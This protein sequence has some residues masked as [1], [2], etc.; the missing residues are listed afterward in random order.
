LKFGSEYA[1][2]RDE[3]ARTAK[4]ESKKRKPKRARR[5]T[6]PAEEAAAAPAPVE[7]KE[8]EDERS[9]FSMPAAA[10]V[11]VPVV[12]EDASESDSDSD[13]SVDEEVLD[14]RL[15]D[16]AAAAPLAPASSATVSSRSSLFGARRAAAPAPASGRRGGRGG[17]RGG[18]RGDRRD[19]RRERRAPTGPRAP[20]RRHK[21]AVDTNIISLSLGHLAEAAAPATGDPVFCEGCGAALNALSNVKDAAGKPVFGPLA[22]AAE[23]EDKKEEDDAAVIGDG[24]QHWECEF[25]GFD[26]EVDVDE[27]E[28]PSEASLEYLL[29][30]GPAAV[31]HGAAGGEEGARAADDAMVVYVLD[32]SGS[33]CVSHEVQGKVAFRGDRSGSMRGLLGRGDDTA[34]RLP[35]QRKD[36]T[37]V[38]RLQAVQAA[39]TSQIAA[40][41]REHPNQRAA[42]I[43]FNNEVCILGDGTADPKTLAGDRLNSQAQML[44]AG[45]EVAMPGAVESTA[46]DLTSK[47][48]ALEEG[49]ATALGP[50][51]AAAVGL[52]SRKAGSRI[53]LA[54]D[55]L[56]NVGLGSLEVTDADRVAASAGAV[57]ED[58]DEMSEEDVARA[59]ATDFYTELGRAAADAGVVVDVVGLAACDLEMLGTT[60]CETTGGEV[61]KVDPA[62]LR[63]EFATSLANPVLAM[64]VTATLLLH[65]GLAFRGDDEDG[66]AEGSAPRALPRVSVAGG[67]AGGD[68]ARAPMNASKKERDIGNVTSDTV[69]TFEYGQKAVGELGERVSEMRAL[70]SL[71]FQLQVRYT[72]PDGA[73]YVRVLSQAKPVTHERAAAEAGM[74][75]RVCGTHVAQ[76]SAGLARAGHYKAARVRNFAFEKMMRRNVRDEKQAAGYGAWAAAGAAMDEVVATELEAERAEL[77][78]D[79]DAFADE[80]ADAPAAAP[81]VLDRL[82]SALGF[83]GGAPTA[84]SAKFVSKKKKKATMKARSSR[85][86]ARDGVSVALQKASRASFL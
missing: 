86:H 45:A 59:R 34:Q 44:A 38:S 43:T 5:A 10:D 51:M 30:S 35:G 39:V 49:G 83:G 82:G 79:L 85:R 64:K 23:G 29:E 46:D 25:C 65:W 56:S 7:R 62:E 63:K 68:G 73:S 12:A 54:T 75:M 48:F 6:R 78:V 27:E 40:L 76:S 22:R 61:T 70:T 26:N 50:A 57:D 9:Y 71:P 72:K 4:K 84:T 3:E 53:V 1:Y 55:G 28:F 8:E 74:D 77:G 36:V 19:D 21:V 18:R 37:Y 47:V 69:L 2:W 20:R 11:P 60:L 31:A 14:H 41:K 24:Q 13:V 42:I 67:G 33:M 15:G 80:A 58:G 81:G 16:V 17:G 32:V 52:A 66:E